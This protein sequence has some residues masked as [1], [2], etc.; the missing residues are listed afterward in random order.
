MLIW[1]FYLFFLCYLFL[2]FSGGRTAKIVGNKAGI[3]FMSVK[4][5]SVLLVLFLYLFARYWKY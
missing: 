3:V 1:L 2:L 5:Q 4:H